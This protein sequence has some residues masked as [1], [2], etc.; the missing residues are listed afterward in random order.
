M[1]AVGTALLVNVFLLEKGPTKEVTIVSSFAARMSTSL[2][3]EAI[4]ASASK[5][6][7]NMVNAERA[8]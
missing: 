1:E 2:S 4:P 6:A 3:K 5:S 7:V 8:G